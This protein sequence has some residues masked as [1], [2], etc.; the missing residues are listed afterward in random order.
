MRRTYAVGGRQIEAEELEDLLAVMP[1]TTNA[2][3]ADL[4]ALFGAVVREPPA[5]A[6][7]YDWRAMQRA[8]WV[9][10][11]AHANV[12]R[13]FQRHGAIGHAR[14]VQRVFL[15]AAGRVLLGADQLCIRLD[16]RLARHAAEAALRDQDLEILY[17]LQFAPRLYKA[18]VRPGRDFLE[19]SL[20]LAGRAPFSYAE[21]VFIEH[22]P[23]RTGPSDPDYVRQWHLRNA[24]QPGADLGAEDAWKLTDGRGVRIAVIDNG[25]DLSHPELADAVEPGTAFFHIE[26]SGNEI[27]VG[28]GGADFP[29]S[30][31]GTFCAALA[32][33][34]RNNDTGGCGVAPEARLLA[35]ACLQDQLGSQCSLARAIE[36][37]ADPSHQAPDLDAGDG[38]D[39]ISCSLGRRTG[40]WQMHDILRNAVDFAVTQG[41]G[42]LGTAIFWSVSNE[43]V[44]IAEDEVCAYANTIAVGSS[45]RLDLAAGHASGPEL[46]FLAPGEWVF[47]ATS[48]G[49]YGEMD[50]TSFA[51]PLA[52]GVGALVL[53]INP[54]LRWHEV[55]DLL[56]GTCDKIGDSGV[57]YV[58]GHHDHYGW[59][60]I[61]AGRAVR[62]ASELAAQP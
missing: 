42:G 60:R 56:R 45:T 33:A 4:A 48:G 19:A 3:D 8:G 61:N 14:G 36:H 58:A 51:A 40:P 38:A 47:S 22:L 31:H 10:V 24:R 41:R 15:G 28:Q 54:R 35:I 5:G 13:D 50:G 9:F 62:K 11:Q 44:P 55:R 39:V 16:D 46:D 23:G 53:S 32:L 21:P 37:A 26:E 49:E 57:T 59:G 25:I 12:L 52:A 30:D 7:P 1:V 43:A 29:V 18:R 27:F 20:H 17:S 2:S 34:R 6:D